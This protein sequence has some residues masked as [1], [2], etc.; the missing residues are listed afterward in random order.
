MNGSLSTVRYEEREI[1][2]MNGVT[3]LRG[4]AARTSREGMSPPLYQPSAPSATI[5]GRPSPR[6]GAERCRLLRKHED[7]ADPAV[8]ERPDGDGGRGAAR[9]RLVDGRDL[10][11]CPPVP[12]ADPDDLML[13]GPVVLDVAPSG[14]LFFTGA[15]LWVTG[16]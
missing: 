12:V 5:R 16:R 1:R 15:G 14:M 11:G 8:I 7:L 6:H 9:G 3:P 10:K 2:R 13:P 4:F